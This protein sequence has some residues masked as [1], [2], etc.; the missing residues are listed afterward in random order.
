[1]PASS[2]GKR[3]DDGKLNVRIVE[4]SRFCSSLLERSGHA[5]GR[6][7]SQGSSPF[8][9]DHSECSTS[10]VLNSWRPFD[11]AR[12][13]ENENS[14]SNASSIN[15]G[16]FEQRVKA[17]SAQ[18]EYEQLKLLIKEQRNKYRSRVLLEKT[19]RKAVERLLAEKNSG[20]LP[21]SEPPTPGSTVEESSNES[22]W[23]SKFMFELIGKNARRTK[24]HKTRR[25][26][27][28]G[29]YCS[30]SN[31]SYRSATNRPQSSCSS[32]ISNTPSCSSTPDTAS[33]RSGHLWFLP[34]YSNTDVEMSLQDC[35]RI[36]RPHVIESIESRRE[37]LRKSRNYRSMLSAKIR[38]QAEHV[39]LGLIS[40]EEAR[41][42]ILSLPRP[43]IYL[44]VDL[45]RETR[46]NHRYLPEQQRKK[47][48][49]RKELELATNR[50][51]SRMVAQRILYDRLVAAGYPRRRQ[52]VHSPRSYPSSLVRHPVE[53]KQWR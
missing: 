51:L 14:E 16:S 25:E 3:N 7:E 28:T 19:K 50:I 12:D 23:S 43:D 17:L 49:Y 30:C 44:N 6:D 4:I 13:D 8:K 34:I 42:A 36:R 26:K 31:G 15:G 53:R 22:D 39:A 10:G 9:F 52:G 29:E 1:M 47:A 27:N 32:Q 46:R 35:L 2:D 33:C 45:V 18:G 41:N 21:R 24:E 37:M 48:E 40:E 5:V 11:A 20:S 38:Q